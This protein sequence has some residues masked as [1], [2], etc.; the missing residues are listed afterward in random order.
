MESEERPWWAKENELDPKLFLFESGMRIIPNWLST[1]K[2]CCDK[3]V[4][5]NLIHFASKTRMD[6]EVEVLSLVNG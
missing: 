2:S 1:I 3:G 4:M 5:R 6:Q